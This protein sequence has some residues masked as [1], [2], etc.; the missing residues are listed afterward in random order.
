M[1]LLD[2]LNSAVKPF[3]IVLLAAAIWVTTSPDL[4]RSAE[5][6]GHPSLKAHPAAAMP[7][8]PGERLRFRLRWTVLPA[9]EAVLEVLPFQTVNG[10]KAYHFRLIANSNLLVDQFYKVRDRIDAFASIDMTRTI[11]Y[12]KKQHEGDVHHNVEV[13]F[14]WDKDIAHYKDGQSVSA[15]EILPGTFDPL[16]VFYYSRVADFGA[17]G[18]I[19][20]PVSDGKKCVIGQARIIKKETIKVLCGWYDTYLIEPDLKHVGGVFKK[21]KDAKIKIWVTADER[22]MPV[23]IASKVAVGSFVGELVAVEN[24]SVQEKI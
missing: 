11:R 23:K 5:L 10:Q 8:A 14:D 15:I 18:R 9:G 2:F 21:S 17:D 3:L 22:R 16:S 1:K 20:C 7:F 12:Y 19:R 24:A 4:L 6:R 13:R